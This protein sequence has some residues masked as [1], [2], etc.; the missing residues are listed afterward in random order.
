VEVEYDLLHPSTDCEGFGGGRE[1]VQV[2]G[3]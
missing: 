1:R 3:R 2:S